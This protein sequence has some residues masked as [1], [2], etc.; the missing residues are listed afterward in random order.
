MIFQVIADAD[1]SPCG[2][3]RYTLTRVWNQ[4]NP[5]P[6][7]ICFAG[8]NPSTADKT[9]NDHTINKEMTLA[10]LWGFH[11]LF[12]IN[13][14]PWRETAPSRLVR[15]WANESGPSIVG[16]WGFAQLVTAIKL[17]GAPVVVC[18]WGTHSKRTF[19]EALQERGRT[20]AE[21]AAAS[22]LTLKC[23][24]KNKDG[25]P[26]HTARLAFTTPLEPW[27]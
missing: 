17:A 6:A 1:M 13:M 25:S 20:F 2:R 27:P 12:K 10:K 4:I 21:I 16:D 26:K 23:L 18:A 24:G 11:G 9:V 7:I 5:A 3:Y 19:N 15:A 22:G 14:Y 8:L